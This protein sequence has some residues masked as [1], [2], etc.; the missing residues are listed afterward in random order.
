MARKHAGSLAEDRNGETSM[1]L[2]VIGQ[3]P[4]NQPYL[5]IGEIGETGRCIGTI[6]NANALR[7]LARAILRSLERE[8]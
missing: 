3:R 8:P 7:G 1:V 5:W 6:Q 2:Q 4:H